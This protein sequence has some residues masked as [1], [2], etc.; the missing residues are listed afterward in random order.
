M[1]ELIIAKALEIVK[2]DFMQFPD[3]D[4]TLEFTI[5]DG[6]TILIGTHLVDEGSHDIYDYLNSLIK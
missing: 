5:K 2:S 3:F 1:E 6:L 4:E